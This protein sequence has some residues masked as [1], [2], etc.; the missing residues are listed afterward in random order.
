MTMTVKSILET[1]VVIDIHWYVDSR[2]AAR[3]VNIIPPTTPPQSA[4]FTSTPH[5]SS[6]TSGSI[7]RC[8][9]AHE[10]NDGVY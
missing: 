5:H 8:S 9:S 6:S 10:E 2:N 3:T 4:T 1:L 7:V